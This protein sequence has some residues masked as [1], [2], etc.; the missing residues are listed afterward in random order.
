[1]LIE[2]RRIGRGENRKR[3]LAV[4]TDVRQSGNWIL[5]RRLEPGPG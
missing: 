1:M 3:L 2:R 4:K 5:A